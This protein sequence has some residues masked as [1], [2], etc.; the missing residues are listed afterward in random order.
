MCYVF[1]F[2]FDFF[3]NYFLE[4]VL[5]LYRIDRVEVL[6]YYIINNFVILYSVWSTYFLNLEKKYDIVYFYV[7]FCI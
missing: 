1:V 3:N 6:V 7:I 2:G 5:L 4:L